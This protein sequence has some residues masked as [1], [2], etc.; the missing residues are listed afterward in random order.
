MAGLSFFEQD[1]L[2]THN[3]FRSLHA[4]VGLLNWN[5]E[6]AEGARNWSQFLLQN[7]SLLHQDDVLNSQNLGENLGFVNTTP[8][9]PLC[10]NSSQTSCVRCSQIITAWYNEI[11]NY[12]FETGSPVDPNEQWLHFTQM[13][14]RV[15]TELGMGVASGEGLH[16]FVA[17][18]KPRG[19]IRGRFDRNVPR[20]RPTGL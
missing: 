14:W 1:C 16:Y 19:N 9:Q 6:L 15:S 8:P 18:Y 13:V 11:S 3:N 4:A 7:Q 2:E 17:R 12:N 10:S 5:A 20:L